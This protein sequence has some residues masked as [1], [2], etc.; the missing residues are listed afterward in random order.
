MKH[1]KNWTS[2][3]EGMMLN[4]L[5]A[6]LFGSNDSSASI[7]KEFGS[8][9]VQGSLNLD[10]FS[11]DSSKNAELIKKYLSKHGMTNPYL[12]MAILGCV[13]KESGFVPKSE[14][15]YSSTSNNRLRQLFGKSLGDLSDSEL[16]Q[17]KKDDN[18]FY[19]RIY[20]GKFGNKSE[21]DGYKYRGR[22]FNQ[23]TFKGNYEKIQKLFTS[24]G[25]NVDIVNN[26]DKLNDPEVAAEAVALFFKAGFD[27]PK[28]YQK[29]GL[30][31]PNQFKNKEDAIQAAV[32]LNAGW[33]DISKTNSNYTRALEIANKMNIKS[34]EGSA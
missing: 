10:S 3:N 21:G 2:F 9:P 17:I 4:M 31:D 1:V 32:D 29:F 33:K 23:I 24:A 20:G 5:N 27:H 8:S 12:Q 16:D 6:A 25:V 18:A 22:G 15:S 7:K 28:L 13:G 14:L 19:E 34:G 30:K 11:G 26:P